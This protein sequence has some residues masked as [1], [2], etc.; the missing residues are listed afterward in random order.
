MASGRQFETALQGL[1]CVRLDLARE[2]E[3][4]RERLK[5]DRRAA[6]ARS[7]QIGEKHSR[8]APGEFG[9]ETLG[10][11]VGGK[12]YDRDART[13]EVGRKREIAQ[14]GPDVERHMRP[15]HDDGQASR[16]NFDVKALHAPGEARRGARV[17]VEKRCADRLPG[18]PAHPLAA[19][20]AED[21]GC[22]REVDLFDRR[23]GRRGACASPASRA[24]RLAS[25]ATRPASSSA[26]SV[27]IEHGPG[28][29][30]PDL[31]AR[32]RRSRMPQDFRVLE[33]D[34]GDDGD[35]A[36]DDVGGIEPSA[37]ADFDHRPLALRFD[38]N[39]EGGGSEEVEP[40]RIG[41]RRPGPAGGLIGVER[42]IEGS[43]ERGLVDIVSLYAHPL[44][45]ALDMGGGVAADTKASMRQRR[46]DQGR[47]RPLALGARDMDRAKR[48][49]RIAEAGGE[50]PHRLESDTHFVPRPALPVGESVEARHCVREIMILGHRAVIPE[51]TA[52]LK[53]RWP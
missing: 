9:D 30:D 18:T 4:L 13:G 8:G 52:F 48:L 28:L 19:K 39:D 20:L 3:R 27:V 42:L 22:E 6:P 51:S 7:R 44:G 45:D 14:H 10:V 12:R 33:R 16:P 46:F 47:D 31:L 29:E 26:S 25:A 5:L 35:F 49:L 38:E 40:G 34:V 11:L 15:V 37:Q 32:D 53:A 36:V 1:F 50:I 2:P 24:R 23:R 43:R 41:G 21:G 17:R